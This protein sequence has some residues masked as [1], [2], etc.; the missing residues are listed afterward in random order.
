MALAKVDIAEYDYNLS[1]HLIA[2][3]P[4]EPRDSSRLCVW[5]QG[6][7]EHKKEFRSIVDYFREGDCLVVNN[8]RV[9]PARLLGNR[10]SGG[11]VEVFL[12]EQGAEHEWVIIGK[13]GRALRKGDKILF[14]SSIE[15]TVVATPYDDARRIVRFNASSEELFKIGHIPLPPYIKRDATENDIIRYQTVYAKEKGAVAAPTA[16]LHFTDRL[17]AVLKDKGVSVTEITLH[18]GLGTFKPV[19]SVDATEHQV[20]KE[21]YSV[22]KESCAIINKT[23]EH[24]GKVFAS[25]TTVAKALETAAVAGMP[26]LERKGKS[27]LYIYPPFKFKVVD[28]LISNFHV[29]KSTLM[30]LV[31]AFIGRDNVLKLY[32][33]A[34]LKEYRFLSYGDA[35][36]LLP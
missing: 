3:H 9:I 18:V 17:L 36:L 25:G 30:L 28:A 10:E 12:I 22:S 21:L 13:P 2:Q 7:I 11:K 35:T 31:S 16:G 5:N 23:R 19:T 34:V 27:N 6:K 1:E 4:V 26:L 15:A 20:D 14:P 24:G 33:E 8:T 32:N 29:P